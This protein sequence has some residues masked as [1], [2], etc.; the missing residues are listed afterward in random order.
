MATCVPKRIYHN[1]NDAP[2]SLRSERERLTRNI[3]IYTRRLCP[4]WQT[5]SDLAFEATERLL[6]ELQWDKA[7]LLY[8][9]RCV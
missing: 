1:I 5:F 7:C 9:S 8:T 4:G 6:A 3:G 2:P